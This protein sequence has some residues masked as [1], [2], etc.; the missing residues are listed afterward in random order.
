MAPSTLD[1]KAWAV[2]N[3]LGQNFLLL[4]SHFLLLLSRLLFHKHFCYLLHIFCYLGK[5][6]LNWLA[7][8]FFGAHVIVNI[9][10]FG[11]PIS[12]LLG[13]LLESW[14]GVFCSINYE[15]HSGA[16][17]IGC[18]FIITPSSGEKDVQRLCETYCWRNCSSDSRSIQTKRKHS[19]TNRSPSHCN[20]QCLNRVRQRANN[21]RNRCQT[22]GGKKGQKN[23]SNCQLLVRTR[24]NEF[25]S[26]TARK[27]DRSP[28]R[29]IF[30]HERP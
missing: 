13:Q 29:S 23:F 21:C 9:P 27:D 20:C 28:I 8:L 24:P 10:T 18:V 22:C 3:L 30:C 1:P 16:K 17:S 25:G 7:V 26:M 12:Q 15:I 19:M 6:R 5:M 4:L 11:L 14:E 2:F